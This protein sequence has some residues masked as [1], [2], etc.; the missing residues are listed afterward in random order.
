MTLAALPG[1]STRETAE[2]KPIDYQ[3]L[4]LAD[5]NVSTP[6][7]QGLDPGLVL[8]AYQKAQKLSSIYSLLIVKNGYLVAEGYFH[9][10]G[11]NVAKPT[12]SVTKS[13]VSSLAGIALREHIL[14]SLDQTVTGFFPEVDWPN[15]D[16]R[17]SQ[18]TVRQMLQMRSG[19]PWE[20]FSGHI[21][22]LFSTSDWIP[23]I[24]EFPLTSDPGTKFG[25]SNLTAHLLAIILARAADTS[26]LDFAQAH[27]FEPLG[28]QPGNW[29]RDARGYC[30]GSGDL[31]LVP[32]DMAKFG[33]LFLNS[34]TFK[35]VQV[36]PAEW[37]SQSLTPVSFNV[38]GGMV[39]SRPD[40][41]I[42][43]SFDTLDYG[44]LW[45]SSKAGSHPF[46]YAWGH[47]GQLIVLVHDL[48]MVVVTSADHL[49]GQ[50][51]DAAWQKERAVMEI[52]GEF[53]RA[54]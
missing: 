26:L 42:L 43:S 50:F 29:P 24:E 23:F 38:Y 34:G 16:P 25:Y 33:L 49:P 17:K 7:A 46:H 40:G 4:V 54:I 1:C 11:H 9:G 36:I 13:F 14:T 2:D 39:P 15:T 3:P 51:G 12:A 10:L 35:G 30:F 6:E 28:I 8:S 5:W 27:L 32:R 48:N 22:R 37:V 45:W 18:I 47:G 21:D 41:R 53:I 31:A 19:F 20:E 44:Y 52:V